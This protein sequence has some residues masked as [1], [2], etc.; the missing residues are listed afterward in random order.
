MGCLLGV[1]IENFSRT[2]LS[3]Q[4]A[5]DARIATFAD[6]L[7]KKGIML[8]DKSVLSHLNPESVM[9]LVAGLFSG[10][11]SVFSNIV[12]ILLT[13]TFILLE[14]SGF[15]DKLRRALGK[16]DASFSSII[17]FGDD[18][19]HYLIIKTAINLV[20]G[21]LIWL[22][23]TI[24]G[25]EFAVL[26]GLLAFLLH[27]IPNIGSI[28]S[29]IP[30]VLL[31]LIVDGPGRAALVIGGYAAIGFVLGN[32]VEPQVMGRGLGLSTL[33][34]FLSLVF[35]GSLFGLFGMV[36]SVPMTMILKLAFESN[37]NTRWLAVLLGPEP[38][39]KTKKA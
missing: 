23:L 37:E 24:L 27:Y 12:L 32:V 35:W 2:V 13:V 4:A 9:S 18:L 21:V 22:W 38:S 15:P 29:A 20:F 10:L 26:W 7:S 31:V 39:Q 11:S 30:A 5:F 17:K 8:P 34:V 3:L 36:L 19:K 33:V 6:F 25:V 14:A 1:S 28:L 16:P